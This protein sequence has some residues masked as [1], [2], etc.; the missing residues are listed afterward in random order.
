[1]Q[2][3]LILAFKMDPPVVDR[4]ALSPVSKVPGLIARADPRTFNRFL[5]FFLVTIRNTNTRL[6]YARVTSAF[7][8]WCEA[9]GVRE[10]HD[11]QPLLVAAYI[12]E[13]Q[14]SVSKPSVKQHLAGIRMLFDWLVI[15]HVVATNP[16]TS[17]R[18]PRYSLEKGM[19]PVLDRDQARTLLNSIDVSH[20]VGLR[21]RA[22]IGL[23]T[24]TF[25]RVSAAIGLRVE[26]YYPRGKRWRVR[27]HEK[28][29]KVIDAACHHHLETYLDA[30]LQAAGIS[31]DKKGPLFRVA[32]GK[33]RILTDKPMSRVDVYLMIRRRATAA[34]IKEGIG[35]HTFRAT[36]IT[37][38]LANGG[39]LELAQKMAGHSS[40][41]T[42]ILYDRRDDEISLDEVERIAI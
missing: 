18:G 5:E 23:L 28:N 20:M 32:K 3:E 13:L 33:I 4:Q 37:D 7:L 9:H 29:G 41:R 16:A 15:G 11:I 31:E 36:G 39:K 6:A 38:Y 2:S 14:Q 34:G 35:C 17:V 21:D 10:L 26:D 30:Y 12:E 42:T 27:L 24:Y 1:M 19:T 22:I 25:A 8:N 40:P